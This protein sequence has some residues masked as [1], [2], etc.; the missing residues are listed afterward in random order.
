MQE[1]LRNLHKLGFIELERDRFT[2]RN[3]LLRFSEPVRDLGERKAALERL[4]EMGE[5]RIAGPAG[6]EPSGSRECGGIRMRRIRARALALVN[7]R[8]VFYERYLIDRHVTALEGDNGA[9]KTT[10]MIAAYVV[11]LPDMSRLRFM[12]IGESGATGGDRG[13]WGRLGEPGRPS[14][15]AIEFRLANGDRLLAGIHL[16]RRGEPSVVP[17]PF[18]ITGLAGDIPLHEVL[19]LT[20]DETESVPELNELRE[21]ATRLGGHFKSYATAREYLATSSTPA[22]LP[23]AFPGTASAASSM[24]C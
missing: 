12:N 8:G 18:L 22:S 16:L 21:N 14:Y 2:L 13:I 7:W 17:T 20:E 24:P 4:I 15:S 11:L 6:T 19:V 10:V 9:G 1:A 3:S 23:C 5:V